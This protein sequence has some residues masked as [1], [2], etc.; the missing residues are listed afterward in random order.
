MSFIS[1]PKSFRPKIEVIDDC[2]DDDDHAAAAAADADDEDHKPAEGWTRIQIEQDSHPTE[3]QS[4]IETASQNSSRPV[5]QQSEAILKELQEISDSLPYRKE[6]VDLSE[7]VDLEE[8]SKKEQTREKDV[9][10]KVTAHVQN[11][12]QNISAVD[13][14]LEGLD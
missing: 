3:E 6:A 13:E 12:D 1:Q 5:D 2:D 11:T 14:E 8:I 7:T 4:P 9:I 10:D